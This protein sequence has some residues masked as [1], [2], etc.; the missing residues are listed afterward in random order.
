[1]TEEPELEGRLA[2]AYRAVS[3]P[4]APDRLREVLDELPN[5][6]VRRG[7]RGTGRWLLAGLAAA[8]AVIGLASFA[9]LIGRG[10]SSAT[11]SS[12]S[13]SGS[14][15]LATPTAAAT[16]SPTDPPGT[17]TVS[18]VLGARAKGGLKEVS[19]ALKGYWSDRSF[20]HSCAAPHGQ[21]G[22][23]EFYCVDGEFGITEL[24]EPIFT[25]LPGGRSQLPSG[26]HLSPWAPEPL[27]R[28]LFQLP[29]A[30]PVGD[31]ITVVRY[32]P[33]P[34]VVLGHFDDPRAA[35]CRPEARQVC[36][37][38]FVIDEI[39]SF[40]PA[41]VPRPTPTPVPSP[42]PFEDPPPAKFGADMCAGDIPY[43]FVGWTTM[44]DLGID[45][46]GEG[47]IYAMVTRDVIALSGW[48]DDP[49][50]SGGRFRSLGRQVCYAWEWD[51]GAIGFVTLPGSGYREWDDG[52]REQ[53]DP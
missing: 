17:M 46:G 38:R 26:A 34:I 1:M 22:E 49:N 25:L 37:D 50:G 11:A 14:Q 13:P 47:H 20:G 31:D 21:P 6:E 32:P 51:E 8:V 44:A 36:L 33:V 15:D 2:R 43:S 35:D 24:D 3:L 28:K 16:A 52:H 5:E 27:F 48:I 18:E 41:A 53:V 4:P 9:G 39:I 45:I 23:L 30:H 10:P 42:F 40:D 7:N 19:V 12:A 29:V